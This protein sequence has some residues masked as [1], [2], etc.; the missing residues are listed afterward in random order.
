MKWYFRSNSSVEIYCAMLTTNIHLRTFNGEE[1][2]F[3][4]SQLNGTIFQI[5]SSL[6]QPSAPRLDKV[7]NFVQSSRSVFRSTALLNF[8]CGAPIH[9]PYSICSLTPFLFRSLLGSRSLTTNSPYFLLVFSPSNS[10]ERV[11]CSVPEPLIIII[12][13]LS[14]M[15]ISIQYKYVSVIFIILMSTVCVLYA[16]AVVGSGATCI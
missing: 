7:F 2:P 4:V 5:I 10:V 12:N 1:S 11:A 6:P 3:R 9:L 8:H 14:K 15:H 16:A 13:S